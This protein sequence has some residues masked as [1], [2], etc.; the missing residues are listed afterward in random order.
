[1]NH[2][3]PRFSESE[4]GIPTFNGNVPCWVC[5]F[6]Q[7]SRYAA[8][9]PLLPELYSFLDGGDVAEWAYSWLYEHF[10]DSMDYGTI[11]GDTGTI[12]EWLSDRPEYVEE[13]AAEIEH[14]C[15]EVRA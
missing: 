1:M 13:L 7:R 6:N 15:I 10:Y 14:H 12:D 8:L 2:N 5:D 3:C 4:H 9:M 11:T